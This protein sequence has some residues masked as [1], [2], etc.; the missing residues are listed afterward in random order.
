MFLRNTVAIL[1]CCYNSVL[2]SPFKCDV[3]ELGAKE[4]RHMHR[5][6]SRMVTVRG[7][8]LKDAVVG[9]T[10]YFDVDPKGMDGHIDMEVVGEWETAATF[11]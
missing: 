2:G 11:V 7:E 5:K 9:S 3:L 4:M 10:T 8:G 6:E 1:I